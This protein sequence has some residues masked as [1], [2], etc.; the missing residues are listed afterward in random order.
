VSIISIIILIALAGFVA[1]LVM[2]IPMPP[3]F[4]NVLLGVLI[5]LLIIWV[6][7]QLGVMPSLGGLRIK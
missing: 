6:L 4:R 2:Q 5:L 7:Q 1:W 3:P